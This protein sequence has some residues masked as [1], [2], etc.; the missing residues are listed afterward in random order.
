MQPEPAASLQNIGEELRLSPSW[1]ACSGVGPS[2]RKERLTG[3]A[4]TDS[5]SLKSAPD[6][7]FNLRCC[8]CGVLLPGDRIG[9]RALL[10]IDDVEFDLV[11]FLQRLV[12]V[13]L[14][15]RIMNENVRSILTADES[16]PL[17][18]VEPLDCAFVLSHGISPFL[19]VCWRHL[20]KPLICET[21]K[22]E[23]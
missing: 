21:Q 22:Q 1:G 19:C 17:G 20:G 3:R 14:N 6:P 5:H 18:V 2:K 23:E 8:R 16:E 10:T 13:H 9:L 7:V 4:S 15:C 12:T 11:P